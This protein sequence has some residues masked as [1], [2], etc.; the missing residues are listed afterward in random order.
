M[1]SINKRIIEALQAGEARPVLQFIAMGFSPVDKIDMIEN[2][3]GGIHVAVSKTLFF[4]S[5]SAPRHD[6]VKAWW[7]ARLEKEWSVLSLA[8][9]DPWLFSLLEDVLRTLAHQGAT[10]GVH[11]LIKK[12]TDVCGDPLNRDGVLKKINHFLSVQEKFAEVFD[13]WVSIVPDREKFI[14]QFI[15][16]PYLL[17][18]AINAGQAL[19]LIEYVDQSGLKHHQLQQWG[20]NLESCLLEFSR[21]TGLFEMQI[22]DAL[23][24]L[25]W[26]KE[27]NPTFKSPQ[28]ELVLQCIQEGLLNVVKSLAKKYMLLHT[29]EPSGQEKA[30]KK[31]RL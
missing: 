17:S 2:V 11:W 10:P 27:K 1:S 18:R 29:L 4:W 16:D 25:I 7:D 23:R 22:E 9:Q 3:L 24:G 19:N 31:K 30:E 6:G 26:I 28:T 13:R 12:L 14:D 15:Q 20:E 21:V 5:L 8:D